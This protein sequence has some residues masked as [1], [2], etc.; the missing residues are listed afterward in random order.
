MSKA[1]RR[2]TKN[3]SANQRR[4]AQERKRDERAIR[5]GYRK[6]QRD[7]SYLAD[8]ENFAGFA[9]QIQTV[10]LELRDVPGDGNCLFRA[11]GDQMDGHGRNHLKHRAE[12]VQYI[13][14]HRDDFEPFV[15]DDVPFD[16]HIENLAKSGTYAGNDS[17]VAFARRHGLNVVIHQLNAPDWKVSGSDRPEARELHIAYHNGDHYSSVRKFGDKSQE[18]TKFKSSD[19]RKHVDSREKTKHKDTN[20]HSSCGASAGNDITVDRA[21]SN[22]S[23]D[24][25]VLRIMDATGCQDA[26]LISDTLEDN[27]YDVEATIDFILQFLQED[28]QP[29]DQTASKDATG[30]PES[31]IWLPGGTGSRLFGVPVEGDSRITQPNRTHGRGRGRGQRPAVNSRTLKQLKRAEKKERQTE[32]HKLKVLGIQT[33][34]RDEHDEDAQSIVSVPIGQMGALSI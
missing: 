3:L 22:G 8:D 34:N 32:R 31:S 7:A 11:L 1:N 16:R 27:Q 4:D 13:L 25:M 17:I 30:N 15:E 23:M 5:N 12:T 33:E 9:T 28:I 24:D 2:Q 6:Q 29:D 26:G 14:E 20:D 10:G 18:P 21:W 19:P